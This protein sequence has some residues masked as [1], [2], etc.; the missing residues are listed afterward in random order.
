MYAYATSPLVPGEAWL[1]LGFFALAIPFG[2][3]SMV[4]RRWKPWWKKWPVFLG[5]VHTPVVP[6]ILWAKFTGPVL[7]LELAAVAAL[8]LG[9]ATGA[10]IFRFRKAL[11]GARAAAAARE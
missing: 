11:F 6:L 4:V 3:L 9:H 10:S 8:L 1:L 2:A 5:V 7:E